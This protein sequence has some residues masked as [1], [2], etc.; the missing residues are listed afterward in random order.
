M[1]GA[2][3]TDVLIASGGRDSFEPTFTFHG[4]RY[5]EIDGWPGEIRADDIEA[6]VVHSE[7]Q[8]TGRFSCSDPLVDRLVEN[9]VWGQKGNFLER[10]HR[11][12]AAR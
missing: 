11:L 8:R 5:A 7:M 9:S 3:A 10:A 2:E 6:V 4:F 1:R 12:P